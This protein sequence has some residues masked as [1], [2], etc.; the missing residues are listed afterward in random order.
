MEFAGDIVLQLMVTY[1]SLNGQMTE[2]LEASDIAQHYQLLVVLCRIGGAATQTELIRYLKMNESTV[3]A[4][5]L[6]L[7]QK[8]YVTKVKSNR[9]QRSHIIQVT[10]LAKNLLGNI[11]SILGNVD[12]VAFRGLDQAQLFQFWYALIKINQNLSNFV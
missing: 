7:E 9:D 4:S 3:R 6:V 12:S 11:E 5:I 2:L 10:T 1:R 8:G